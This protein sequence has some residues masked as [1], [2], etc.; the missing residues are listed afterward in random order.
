[1]KRLFTYILFLFT[2]LLVSNQ[3]F[4][5]SDKAITH[6]SSTEASYQNPSSLVFEFESSDLKQ[7]FFAQKDFKDKIELSESE[8]ETEDSQAFH[9]SGNF[10][11]FE[12]YLPTYTSGNLT[13]QI[14]NGLAPC[15]HLLYLATIRSF[16][17]IFCV[18]R[19]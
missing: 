18:Y 2:T 6:F 1:M 8:N 17:I 3:L 9:L 10:N 14:Q 5:N 12:N 7:P 19:I 11:F 15:K 16:C 4:A 13:T